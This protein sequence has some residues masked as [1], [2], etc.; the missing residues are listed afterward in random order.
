MTDCVQE[1]IQPF[2]SK[3]KVTLYLSVSE[4]KT[5]LAS[6]TVLPQQSTP[7]AHNTTASLDKLTSTDYV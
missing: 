5:L 4:N 6:E 2:L 7:L 3:S 1:D